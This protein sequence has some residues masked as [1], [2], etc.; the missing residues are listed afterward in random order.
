MTETLTASWYDILDVDRAAP[1][2]EIRAAWRSAVTDLDPTDRRF[3]LY[4]QAAEV[5]L[6]PSRRAAYDAEL[7]AGEPEPALE[8]GLAADP[9]RQ[10]L[11][12]GA[13]RAADRR[14]AAL[15]VVPGWVLGVV[16]ALLALTLVAAGALLAH[17]A[18]SAVEGDAQAAQAAAER[19]VVPLLSYDAHHLDQSRAAVLPLLTPTFRAQYDRFFEGVVQRNAQGL[20][21]VVRARVL[22]SGIVRTGADQVDVL[23]FVDQRTFNRQH[24]TTP[25]VYRDQATLTMVKA[26]GSWLVDGLTTNMDRQ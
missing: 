5:L 1:A 18:D 10:H 11:S 3:R 25:V 26:G 15:P 8:P 22:S 19:D 7:A 20:G 24:R 2:D 21:T 23:V 9:V 4:S 13:E 14:S 17:P 16:S 12:T 6:V